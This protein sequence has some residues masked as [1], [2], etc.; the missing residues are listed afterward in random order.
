MGL[1]QLVGLDTDAD[2]LTDVVELRDH[3]TERY[4]PDSDGD[5]QSDGDEVL[6]L[7]TD[8]N[9]P[10]SLLRI[11]SL[12]SID[13]TT[14]EMTISFDSVGGV[15]YRFEVSSDLKNWNVAQDGGADH[16][17]TASG[18]STTVTLQGTAGTRQFIRVIAP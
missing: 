9:D 13:A 2:G 8:P 10:D 1:I 12:D 15:T 11:G 7:M 18:A 17:V 3:L 14:G 5:G 6:V 16:S 4:H